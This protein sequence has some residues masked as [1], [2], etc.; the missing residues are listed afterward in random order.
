MSRKACRYAADSGCRL[1]RHSFLV[2]TF[3]AEAFPRHQSLTVLRALDECVVAG[4]P[5]RAKFR[6]WILLHAAGDD[7]ECSV[8]KGP[9]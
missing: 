8:R 7:P 2:P 5:L 1:L 4:D 6:R 3:C 9:L